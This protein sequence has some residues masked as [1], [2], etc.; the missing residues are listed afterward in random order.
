MWAKA[1]RASLRRV[2]SLTTPSLRQL[3]QDGPVLAGVN[4]DRDVRAV[5]RRGPDHRRTADVHHLDGRLRLERVQVADD[6]VDRCDVL[7]GEV[8]EMGLDRPVGQDAGMDGRVQ[9][10][11]A[12][13]QHLRHAGDLGN[14]RV[15]D[16]GRVQDFGGAPAGD[17]LDAEGGQ[18]GAN[19]SRPVLS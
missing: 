14:F 6:K 1:A 16:P 11:H 13:S 5:L 12:P 17:Q 3:L 15:I 10:L 9:G 18:A 8:L 19:S 4:D 2:D 7:G